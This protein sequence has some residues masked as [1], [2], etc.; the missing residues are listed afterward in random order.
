MKS[1]K[2][3][4]DYP[5]EVTTK[6]VKPHEVDQNKYGAFLSVYAGPGMRVFAFTTQTCRDDFARDYKEFTCST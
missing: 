4:I 2:S 3:G 5:F 1:P 6:G